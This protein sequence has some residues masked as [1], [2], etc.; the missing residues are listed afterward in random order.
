MCWGRLCTVARL[1]HQYKILVKNELDR[2][3][4]CDNA[5]GYQNRKQQ[6]YAVIKSNQKGGP[7]KWYVTILFGGSFFWGEIVCVNIQ[8][9]HECIT[10]YPSCWPASPVKSVSA[11]REESQAVGLWPGH[12]TPHMDSHPAHSPPQDSYSN[13]YFPLTRDL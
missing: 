7:M 2:N 6:M 13:F 1:S 9:S 4:S 11:A 10:L 12:G 8:Y 5:E 3:K